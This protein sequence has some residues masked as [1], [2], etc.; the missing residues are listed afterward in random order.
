MEKQIEKAIRETLVISN[1]QSIHLAV[2]KILL[3][4]Q[5]SGQIELKPKEMEEQVLKELI[6]EMQLRIILFE[7]NLRS[8]KEIDV[9]HGYFDGKRSEASFMVEKLICILQTKGL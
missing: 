8:N 7:S 2:K 9:Q 6:K 5:N 4:L 3:L 1:P